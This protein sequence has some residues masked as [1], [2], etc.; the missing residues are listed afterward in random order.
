VPFSS[1]TNKAIS[2]ILLILQSSTWVHSYCLA[3]AVLSKLWSI[4]NKWWQTGEWL[5]FSFVN[6]AWETRRG[7]HREGK[8]RFR[9]GLIPFKYSFICFFTQVQTLVALS[10]TSNKCCSSQPGLGSHI[11][12]SLWWHVRF[13]VTFEHLSMEPSD[14]S[15]GFHLPAGRAK[16]G[17]LQKCLCVRTSV[18]LRQEKLKLSHLNQKYLLFPEEGKPG[19]LAESSSSHSPDPPG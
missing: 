8:A 3:E 1:W 10:R 18:K 13:M 19:K 17:S 11:E 9:W 4:C 6:I 12:M 14:S 15:A 2:G 16:T 7:P 5:L